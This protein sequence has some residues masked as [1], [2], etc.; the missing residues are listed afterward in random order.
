MI[1]ETEI[2]GRPGCK[3]WVMH[4]NEPTVGFIDDIEILYWQKPKDNE[5]G[6]QYVISVTYDLGTLG[7]FDNN[8]V[9]C[10][11]EELLNSLR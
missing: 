5:L 6:W 7:K 4:N 2:K 8:K 10:T 9:F 1:F 3:V 11:K